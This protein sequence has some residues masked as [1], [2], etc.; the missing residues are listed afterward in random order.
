MLNG[1]PTIKKCAKY[2]FR[3]QLATLSLDWAERGRKKP[4]VPPSPSISTLS[5]KSKPIAR[6]PDQLSNYPSS[7]FT[8][9]LSFKE[10]GLLRKHGNAEQPRSRAPVVHLNGSLKPNCSTWSMSSPSRERGQFKAPRIPAA[11]TE[12]FVADQMM[13]LEHHFT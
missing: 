9:S 3:Q 11:A 6:K 4:N 12:K 5:F 10:I 2:C 8:H 7:P 1:T 13:Y